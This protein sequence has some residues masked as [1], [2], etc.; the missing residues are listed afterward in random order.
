MLAWVTARIRLEPL[1]AAETFFPAM[2]EL[3]PAILTK[4]SCHSPRIW[5]GRLEF[6]SPSQTTPLPEAAGWT[7]NL[8]NDC[9]A[10]FIFFYRR[11]LP[12]RRTDHL[13][14]RHD[15]TLSVIL[16]VKAVAEWWKI[17]AG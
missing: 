3:H 11:A 1:F 13:S 8:W 6:F 4:Q 17:V 15:L 16:S 5:A 7:E 9:S 12:L 2:L 14:A 10:D